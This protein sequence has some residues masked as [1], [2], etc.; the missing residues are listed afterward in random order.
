MHLKCYQFNLKKS[1]TVIRSVIK[2]GQ[3]YL[4][5]LFVYPKA[6]HWEIINNSSNW[7]GIN[8]KYPIEKNKKSKLHYQTSLFKLLKWKGINTK[9]QIIKRVSLSILKYI[10]TKIIFLLIIIKLLSLVNIRILYNYLDLFPCGFYIVERISFD[11][12]VYPDYLYHLLQID[13]DTIFIFIFLFIT[14]ITLMLVNLMIIFIIMIC[15]YYDKIYKILCFI[16][17]ILPVYNIKQIKK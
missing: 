4:N 9:Y 16:S 1:F 2:L 11:T 3:P 10:K 5:P 15:L 14:I 6:K 17:L 8:N 12:S 13:I 7:E